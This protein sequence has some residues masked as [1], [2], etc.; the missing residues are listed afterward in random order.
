M[1]LNKWWY[2]PENYV[3]IKV[4]LR[5]GGWIFMMYLICEIIRTE[6]FIHNTTAILL[7]YKGGGEGGYKEIPWSVNRLFLQSGITSAF[8][9]VQYVF[10]NFLQ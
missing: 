6:N 5:G 9:F 3:V 10:C 7:K 8:T 4:Q 2:S 1:V